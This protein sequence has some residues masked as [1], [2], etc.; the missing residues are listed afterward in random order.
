MSYLQAISGLKSNTA[1]GT[2]SLPNQSTALADDKMPAFQ[3][4]LL[5]NTP[6]QFTASTS[7][8]LSVKQQTEVM[9]LRQLDRSVREHEHAHMRSAG[10]L[11]VG[12][13]S[14]DFKMGP[15]GRKYAVGG[16]VNIDSSI[17]FDN[18]EEAIEKARRVQGSAT[19]PAD[20]SPKDIRVASHA[21]LMETK[22]HRKINRDQFLDV[23]TE[24]Q[25]AKDHKP[26]DP[27]ELKLPE[28]LSAYKGGLSTQKELYQI[29]DLFT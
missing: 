24:K 29:L 20:P 27:Q 7:R 26:G 17:S 25:E 18:P 16:E 11:A 5:S 28:V 19:A 15:D 10:N 22:A 23:I 8:D 3:Q 14:F 6:H 4:S 21:R 9:Q 1:V 2:P 13:P 12:G